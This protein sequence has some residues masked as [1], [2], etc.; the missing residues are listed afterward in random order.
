VILRAWATVDARMTD[1]NI[2]SR[3]MGH[4]MNPNMYMSRMMAPMNPAMYQPMMHMGKYFVP[5][6]TASDAATV[7][8]N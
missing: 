3:A 1:F 6:P 2:M 7:P 5:L 8:A 4:F